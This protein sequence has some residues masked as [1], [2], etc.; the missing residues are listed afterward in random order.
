M[1]LRFCR[2]AQ[3]LR[4]PSAQRETTRVIAH[5]SCVNRAISQWTSIQFCMV[6]RICCF[7]TGFYCLRVGGHIP[8]NFYVVLHIFIWERLN[9]CLAEK[10]EATDTTN[11][12]L[13]IFH[14]IKTMVILWL[15]YEIIRAFGLPLCLLFLTLSLS[16]LPLSLFIMINVRYWM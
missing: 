15:I 2:T 4:Y 16:L 7:I 6:K 13:G 12:C 3:M 1:C 5:M 8:C 11:T 10:Q 9:F 14:T